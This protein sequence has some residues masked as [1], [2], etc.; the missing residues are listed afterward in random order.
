M[1]LAPMTAIAG[2]LVNFFTADDVQ[3]HQ[4]GTR[5]DAVDSDY[6][7]VANVGNGGGA[8]VIYAKGVGTF[9]TGRLVHLDKDYNILDVPV[10]GNTGRAVH[11]V[12]SNFTAT[13]NFGWIGRC[14]TFPVSFSVAATVGAVFGG[15][16][17]QAT[18]TAAAGRQI[19][20]AVT[21]IASTGAFTRTT[22]TRNGRPQ[23]EVNDVSGMFPGMA[24]SGTGIPGGA[25]IA[26]IDNS[27]NLI[28][29]SA[30][31]TASAS[32][33]GTFT[34]TGFGMVHIDSPFMQG[35][36]T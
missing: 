22:R 18:P 31:A 4:L 36:V 2:K 27:G 1:R 30:N 11:V 14:G 34:H 26:T 21:F 19:L 24:V 23:V 29:L 25:T 6:L 5:M 3:K 15:A 33:T 35:Q 7:A 17:G 16:A 9:A 13:S 28:T 12:L 8:T 32:V 20:N 10:T